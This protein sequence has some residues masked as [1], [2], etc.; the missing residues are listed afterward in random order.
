MPK[1][2]SAEGRAH[3][4]VRRNST[5]KHKNTHIIHVMASDGDL[6]P[7][8]YIS[9]ILYGRMEPCRRSFITINTFE[10]GL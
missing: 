4:A 10:D 9:D 1:G 8:V 7:S 5:A 6:L 3:L 2:H